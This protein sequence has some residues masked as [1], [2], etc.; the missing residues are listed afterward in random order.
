MMYAKCFGGI[1]A[2]FHYFYLTAPHFVPSKVAK[3]VPPF[4][5]IC[6]NALKCYGSYSVNQLTSVV[7]LFFNI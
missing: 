4:F 5:F 3:H 6:P 7:D 2:S 1:Y